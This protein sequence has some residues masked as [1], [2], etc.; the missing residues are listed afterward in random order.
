MMILGCNVDD[1][2]FV[3]D[4][5]DPGSSLAQLL[6]RIFTT[7]L[8]SSAAKWAREDHDRKI[9]AARQ[10]PT[11]SIRQGEIQQLLKLPKLDPSVWWR[12]NFLLLAT[13]QQK[14]YELTGVLK[15]LPG[16]LAADASTREAVVHTG[17]RYLTEFVLNDLEWIGSSTILWPA[18]AAYRAFRILYASSLFG[19]GRN[20][21][22][23]GQAPLPTS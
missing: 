17:F 5:A 8:N 4:Y 1:I 21:L 18:A 3:W 19:V 14:S 12:V 11:Q 15:D 10:P 7:P 6:E 2:A 22:L 23:P 13:H 20:D 16:W 9:A